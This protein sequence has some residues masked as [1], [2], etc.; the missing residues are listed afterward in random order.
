M[1]VAEVEGHLGELIRV[2]HRILDGG[3]V[4][5]RRHDQRHVRRRQGLDG[6]LED[7]AGAGSREH[8]LGPHSH[9]GRNGRE[10]ILLPIVRVAIGQRDS[11]DD[12]LAGRLGQAYGVLVRVQAKRAVRSQVGPGRKERRQAVGL[13]G[14]GGSRSGGDRSQCAGPQESSAIHGTSPLQAAAGGVSRMDN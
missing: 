5:R 6:G 13:G 7:L 9:L 4:R 2:V 10:E 11:L 3:L 12:R 14:G 1:G 8:V